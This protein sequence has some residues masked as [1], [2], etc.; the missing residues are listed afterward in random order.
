METDQH[1]KKKGKSMDSLVFFVL[2][3]A[4]YFG[5]QFFVLPKLGVP[6]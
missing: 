5:L 2:F 6:T 4:V 3:I 1:I